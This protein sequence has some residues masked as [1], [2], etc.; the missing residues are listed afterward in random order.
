VGKLEGRVALITG[1][2]RG[3]GAEEARLFVQEGARVIV[4]DVL[5]DLGE[6]VA[7]ELGAAAIYRRLDVTDP[8]GWNAAVEAT[9]AA[10]GRLDVLVNNAGVN[11]TASIEATSP[12]D[13]M[14][15]VSVNQLGTWLGIKSVLPA[16]RAGGGGSIVNIVSLGAMTSLAD[17]SAYLGS[18]W[19]VRGMTKCL[20]SELGRH[21][22]RVNAVHPGGIATSMTEGISSDAYEDLPVPRL[23][24]ADEIARAVLFFASDDSSYC[25]GAELV[26]DGGKLAN[27]MATPVQPATATLSS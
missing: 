9:V 4:S 11:L 26:V 17:K 3:Q 5:D 20:A 22:I 21:R 16:M 19:A 7:A 1:S 23:G 14:H 6:E 10:F 8:A 25:T 15:I 13:F 24:R 2:A 18:K 27:A 12:N